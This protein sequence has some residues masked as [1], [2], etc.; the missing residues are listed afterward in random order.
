MDEDV[1]D[2]EEE[3]ITGSHELTVKYNQSLL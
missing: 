3:N 1:D 2:E